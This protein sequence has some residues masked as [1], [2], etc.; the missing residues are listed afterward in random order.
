M[1]CDIAQ[2]SNY[3]IFQRNKR[4]AESRATSVSEA[5]RL[6]AGREVGRE[7]RRRIY[8]ESGCPIRGK[9]IVLELGK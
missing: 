4:K 9:G 8:A 1:R 3:S 7:E 2:P 5:A 6:G